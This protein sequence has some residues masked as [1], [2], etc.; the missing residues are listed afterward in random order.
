MHESI[1]KDKI[2]W[3]LLIFA[4]IYILGNIGTGSLSTW[5]EALYANISRNIIKTGDWLV[6]RQGAKPWFDKP[7]LY[8]WC[9]AVFY[10]ILGVSEFSTR[11]TSGLFGIATVMVL[12]LFAKK[13]ADKITAS[14]AGL[15]LLALPHYIHF[16]KLGM[17]DVPITFFTV[18]TIYLFWLGQEKEKYLFYSGALVGLA[19]LMK[20]F[21]GFLGPVII[22]FYSIFSKNIRLMFKRQFLW[23]IAAAFLIIFS[24]H[25]IQFRLVGPIALKEYFGFHIYQR[26]ASVLDSH[27]GGINFYQKV[28]FNKNIPWSVMIYAS[29]FYIAWRSLKSKDKNAIL[30]LSWVAAAYL[31][32][33]LVKTKLHWYIMPIYPAM[34]LSS[35]IFLRA[36]LKN[37]ILYFSLAVVLLVMLAQ[38]PLSRAFN[39]DFTPDVK[40]VSLLSEG[41]YRR[42]NDIYMIGGNDSELFYCDFAKVLDKDLYQS[43]IEQGKKGIYCIILPELLKEKKEEYNFDYEPIYESKR[44]SLY[45]ITFKRLLRPAKMRR[46]SQ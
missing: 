33:S 16:S 41:L 29:L 46:G 18:L 7:P 40:R 15:I 43:L 9:T 4:S 24:W 37:K 22:V 17:M 28:I 32:Y 12:Y 45:K 35:A 27:G 10:K 26:A 25:L 36:F 20:G 5:D 19:Y 34:A 1:S 13:M 2:F 23:G 38:V 42:G 44:T 8:M 3:L 39:L 31:L 30:L 11:L 14:F 6:M 21:A